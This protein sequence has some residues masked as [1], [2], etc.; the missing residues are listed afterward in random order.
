MLKHSLLL[1]L[2]LC[3]LLDLLAASEVKPVDE[4]TQLLD[5]I[6]AVQSTYQTASGNITYQ[7]SYPKDKERK[8]E[9][10]KA[11][12]A[13]Q[14]PNRYRFVVKQ[15]DQIEYFIS[16]G[17][18]EWHVEDIGGHK[19]S[20]K[21][22]LKNRKGKFAG[23]TDYIPLQRKQLAKTFKMEAALVD[24]D[25]QIADAH[26]LITLKPLSE[27]Q[28]DHVKWTKIYFDKKYQACG[29]QMLDA[30]GNLYNITVQKMA[31]NKKL[32]AETFT[33]TEE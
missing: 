24:K 26:C 12:L 16:N 31:Y 33:Y 13:V 27:D 22:E 18:V 7:I 32:P 11:K 23:I 30:K 17:K 29:I 1:F 25:C 3:P 8:A 10:Y 9:T 5:S 21:K 20:S 19:V 14:V 28:K 2:L 4:A 6:I 15:D